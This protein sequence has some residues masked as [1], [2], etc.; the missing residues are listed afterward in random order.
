MHFGLKHLDF[1]SCYYGASRFK[2]KNFEILND[3]KWPELIQFIGETDLPVLNFRQSAINVHNI[4]EITCAIGKNPVSPCSK[5]QVLNLAKNSIT[6][7]GAKLLAPALEVN[8]SIEFLD[9]SQNALGVYG[10]VLIARALQ[11]NS[12]L[13]GLNLF[14]NTLDVDGAR[15]L[16]EM[17]KVNSTIEFLDIGHNRIRSKGL[18]AISEGI[19]EAKD[20]KL[21]TLGLRMNFIN[22]DG[23]QR[24]FD[25]VILSGMSKIDSLFI[26]QNNLTDFKAIR[27]Q[28]ALT[29]QN[30]KIYVD[31]FEK[32]FRQSEDRMKR[33]IW[34]GP[35]AP[36]NYESAVARLNM[37]KQFNIAKTGLFK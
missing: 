2:V 12:T 31:S 25:E 14:K 34:F 18:E 7:Q 19:L 1:S 27:L 15:A 8:K 9:V 30:M 23:F 10:V 20:S 11:K 5:L 28:K 36:G 21:K 24:F 22:D 33:T 32:L 6:Q 29:D 4:E 17:L 37:I 35:I 3:P 13:K 26:N 16:R